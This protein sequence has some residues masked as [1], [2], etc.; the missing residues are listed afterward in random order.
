MIR[1]VEEK[2]TRGDL[3]QPFLIIG[4]FMLGWLGK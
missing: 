2:L 3:D 4:I 1:I